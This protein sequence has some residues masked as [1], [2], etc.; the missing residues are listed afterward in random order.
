MMG[1]GGGGVV[2]QK[3]KMECKRKKLEMEERVAKVKA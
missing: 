2:S 1:G 3:M